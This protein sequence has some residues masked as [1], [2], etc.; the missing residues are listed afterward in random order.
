MSLKI[1]NWKNF[2]HF[3]DRRPPWIKVHRDILDDYDINMISSDAFKLL[4]QLWLLA[5]EDDKVEGNLPPIEQI[6]YRLRIEKHKCLKLLKELDSFLISECYQDDITSISKVYT[7]D[8]D[9]G[10]DREEFMS[11][12]NHSTYHSA[13]KE[14]LQFLNEKTGRNY[15]PVDANLNFIK[16][17][18]KEGATERQIRQVIAKKCREW[19]GDEKMML[20][21][22][23]AT[24]FNK[25]KFAQ[26]VGELIVVES[27]EENEMSVM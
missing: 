12:K 9:R 14:I 26:Y 21:L 27:E 16:A 11:S 18:L 2:Q 1:K 24:L 6:C 5:S 19:D 8:R 23:P 15:Q 10:R 4:V 3:K 17:R 13:S 20:Y 25:T 22:R 7:R